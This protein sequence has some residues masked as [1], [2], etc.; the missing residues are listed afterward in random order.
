MA[1][2]YKRHK[3]RCFSCEHCWYDHELEYY[4]VYRCRKYNNHSIYIGLT[5]E[6]DRPKWCPVYGP[7]HDGEEMETIKED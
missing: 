4:P 7:E 2:E 6:V 5:G 1:Y 3:N